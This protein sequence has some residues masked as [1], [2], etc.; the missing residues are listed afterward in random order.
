MPNLVKPFRL[1]ANNKRR[2]KPNTP[3]KEITCIGV[4]FNVYPKYVVLNTDELSQVYKSVEDMRGLLEV[5]GDVKI[6]W[7]E[8]EVSV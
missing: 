1:T 4:S 7:L 2:R 5:W 3:F 6:D 8:E